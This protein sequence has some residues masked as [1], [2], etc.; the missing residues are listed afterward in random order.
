MRAAIAE[1]A[2]RDPQPPEPRRPGAERVNGN[3]VSAAYVPD[4]ITLAGAVE[5]R[6]SNP[7]V[8]IGPVDVRAIDCE[9][10][11]V[12]TPGGDEP[13]DDVRAIEV[14]PSDRPAVGPVDVR[15]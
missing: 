14:R 1:A 2:R 13:G 6:P 9:P 11:G 3:G 4:Q 7:D 12:E 10:A 5:V 8:G 15:G